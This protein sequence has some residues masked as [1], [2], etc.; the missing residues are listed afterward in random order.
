MSLL[1]YPGK[2]AAVVFTQGCPFRCP[3]CHNPE[4]VPAD[5]PGA[6]GEDEVLA[7]LGRDRAL[8]DGVCVTGGEPT[9]H[10]DL[11]EFLARLKALGLAVKLDTNGTHP[12]MVER[13]LA[14]GLVDCF[15]MDVKHRWERYA[16]VI[17]A[18]ARAAI[19]L[20]KETFALIQGSG[21]DHEFRTTAYPGAHAAEDLLAIASYLRP[22]ERYFVQPVR[23]GKTLQGD[24]PRVPPDYADAVSSIRRAFPSIT[25]AL[26]GA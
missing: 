8:L 7:R 12:R 14:R 25:V 15:A 10:P 22:G 24:L 11:P 5:R 21:V 2:V 23:Y 6:I 9:T 3:Y 13:C 4:L 20:C 18:Q 26:R 19:P 1:D 16:E 17:G